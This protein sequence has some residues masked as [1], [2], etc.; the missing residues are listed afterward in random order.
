MATKTEKAVKAVR[1]TARLY[2]RVTIHTPTPY[3]ARVTNI[4]GR[5]TQIIV[6]VTS[7]EHLDGFPPFGCAT[8]MSNP[9]RSYYYRRGETFRVDNFRCLQR[10]E[11]TAIADA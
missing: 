5:P 11:L 10:L 6:L 9:P 7:V 4:G 1:M 2:K 3:L 8:V